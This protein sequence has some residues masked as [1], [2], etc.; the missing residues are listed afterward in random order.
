MYLEKKLTPIVSVIMPAW[1]AFQ[2]IDRAI[3]SVYDQNL[4][5]PFELIIVDDGSDDNN[6]T[7]QKIQSWQRTAHGHPFLSIKSLQLTRNSG[8]GTARRAAMELS[9]GEYVCYLDTDDEFF[10]SR[11]LGGLRTLR[12]DPE[13]DIVLSPYKITD[14]TSVS[15]YNPTFILS[16]VA[17]L[18]Q[19]QNISIPLGV[20]HTRKIYSKTSGW[21]QYVVC[22]EDGILWRRMS[23]QGAKFGVCSFMAGIYHIRVKGQSRTQ[24]RFDSGMAFAFDNQNSNGSN[25]QYLDNLTDEQLTQFFES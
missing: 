1:R 8:P 14:G 20:M 11:I 19:A 17:E 5:E 15:V 3:K 9:S 7:W 24:R 4:Q 6:R 21:P 13:L 23:E 10:E 18:L 22:G 16:K 25:G 12:S 2:S